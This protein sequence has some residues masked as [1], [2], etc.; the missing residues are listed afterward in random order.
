[1]AVY[2]VSVLLVLKF[3]GRSLLNLEHDT[4]KHSGQVV[5]T[6]IFNSFILCQIFDAFNARK[7]DEF[8]V[9]R[10]I[11]KNHC[12]MGI[13]GVTV[14][15]QVVIINFLGKYASTVRLNWSQW[16]ISVVIGFISWPL[17]V[18]GKLI[19]VPKTHFWVARVEDLEQ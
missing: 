5:H 16:L 2:Q 15:L 9:F 6:M 19:P 7:P 4:N 10:G 13:V 3:Q 14:L 12:F 1:M 11:T 8:N 17:A 18:L